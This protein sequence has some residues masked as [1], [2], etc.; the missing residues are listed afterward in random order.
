M[1]VAGNCRVPVP[2]TPLAPVSSQQRSLA[3]ALVSAGNEARHQSVGPRPD[4]GT[5]TDLSVG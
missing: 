4:K 3:E 5:M 1:P 2:T